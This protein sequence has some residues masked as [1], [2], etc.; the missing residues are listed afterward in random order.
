MKTNNSQL[1]HISSALL[2]DLRQMLKRMFA[3]VSRS[4]VR[5]SVCANPYVHT[6]HNANAL[7]QQPA[8]LVL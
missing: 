8:R 4:N 1:L 2:W 3:L 7:K 5:T 6:T